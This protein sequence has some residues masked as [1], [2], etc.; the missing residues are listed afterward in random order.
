MTIPGG[1]GRAQ[2][3]SSWVVPGTTSVRECCLQQS[4]H[5][6]TLP[7]WAQGP[8]RQQ[9]RCELCRPGGGDGHS[10][11]GHCEVPTPRSSQNMACACIGA[12]PS[13]W[14]MEILVQ[15]H[16]QLLAW[17]SFPSTSEGCKKTFSFH[18][19]NM[20]GDSIL[21]GSARDGALCTLG[22]D[23]GSGAQSCPTVEDSAPALLAIW[24]VNLGTKDL[25][26]D[27]R[28][29]NPLVQSPDVMAGLD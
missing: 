27:G 21:W 28:R 5:Q 22:G 29:L 11:W 13:S 12:L 15:K 14:K 7:V 4:S 8:T 18:H 9:Y 20:L 25:Q 10:P 26:R 1:T 24:A 2:L 23:G 6:G 3:L 19:R 17:G 16:S